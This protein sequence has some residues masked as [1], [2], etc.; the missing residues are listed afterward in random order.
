V[1][2]SGLFD[3]NNG[4]N[5]PLQIFT[6]LSTSAYPTSV[7]LSGVTGFKFASSV[8]VTPASV[9][10][11]NGFE[12]KLGAQDWV[13]LDFRGFGGWV[14]ATLAATNAPII[15]SQPQSQTVCAHTNFQFSVTAVGSPPLFYQWSRN[16][17]NIAGATL[18]SLTISN[19]VQTNLGTYAVVVTNAVGSVLSSDAALSMYPFIAVPFAGAV[20][21]WG[22]DA[23]F[24]V[25]A[26]GTG[27]LNYQWFQNGVALENATNQ[28][29]TLTSMQFTNA[30]FYSLVVSSSLGSVTNPPA[31]VVVNPAGVSLGLCPAVTIDG[32]VGYN[33]IIRRT[34]D[35][36]NTNAWV[37]MTNLTLTQPVQLW[38]DTN[39]D[40]SLPANPHHFYQ[41]LPG[42]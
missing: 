25:R 33:Y 10:A 42:Q 9:T 36:S 34:A 37:T 40:A 13:S 27:P 31:Q 4:V 23:T 38:V 17:T 21:Y 11:A 1:S 30:G 39:V 12:I 6:T 20:T 22:K 29:F 5:Q 2:V 41:V 7:A 24:S 14:T 3:A 8:P 35:L 18:S 19:V 16:S 15:T 28:T 26:W 32:V